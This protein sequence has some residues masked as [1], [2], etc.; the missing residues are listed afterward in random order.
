M[1]AN[2]WKLL[3]KA[4]GPC[5]LYYATH[6]HHRV[7]M[8]SSILLEYASIFYAKKKCM[9]LYSVLLY[10]FQVASAQEKAP[11]GPVLWQPC[12]PGFPGLSQRQMC[13][14]FF[15]STTKMFLIF[16]HFCVQMHLP[17]WF[18]HTSMITK[19]PPIVLSVITFQI[20]RHSSWNTCVVVGS[21]PHPGN[22]WFLQRSTPPRGLHRHLK[23]STQKDTPESK[24]GDWLFLSLTNTRG[25]V[26]LA[27]WMWTMIPWVKWCDS[28]RGLARN[29][30]GAP[31]LV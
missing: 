31:A 13:F 24:A 1:I 22:G 26:M 17:I 14:Q 28:K 25:F 7:C 20:L 8:C 2:I 11:K 23:A 29:T 15:P 9:R 27:K 3:L 12:V 19:H 16:Q 6:T 30:V 5:M 4:K 18:S 10:H 21:D